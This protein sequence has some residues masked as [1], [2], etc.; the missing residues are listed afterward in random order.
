MADP[1]TIRFY[2]DVAAKAQKMSADGPP[3][4]A[5]AA[6]MELLPPGGAVLDFGCGHGIATAQMIRAGF[7]VTAQDASEGLLAIARSLAPEAQ[8]VLADFEDL[9]GQDLYDGVWANFALVHAPR[10]RLAPLIAKLHAALR[11]DGILH[12]SM[13]LGEGE[14]RDNLDRA[15]TYVTQPELTG[16][17]SAFEILSSETATKHGA[18]GEHDVIRIRARAA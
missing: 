18:L 15:Y 1:Q 7:S 6:F 16:L 11:P 2:D 10:D 13:I 8:F 14:L 12:L 17:L 3:E 5:L 4:P 9:A